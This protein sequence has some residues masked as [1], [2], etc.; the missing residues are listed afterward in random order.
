MSDIAIPVGHIPSGLFVV[1]TIGEDGQ[2]DGF[3]ASWIQQISF[4]PLLLTLGIKQGRT[5]YDHIVSGKP[6]SINIV[7]DDQAKFLKHFWKGYPPGQGPFHEIPHKVSN[8]GTII[9]L[10]AKSAIECK[11]QSRT[12]PGDHDLVVAEVVGGANIN[13]RFKSKTYIRNSGLDY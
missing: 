12:S 13:P 4:S 7:G 10:E 6:F 11:M 1:C 8:N 5:C 2:K 3:L 9:I